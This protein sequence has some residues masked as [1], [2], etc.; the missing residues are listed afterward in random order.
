[1]KILHFSILLND[2]KSH[3]RHDYNISPGTRNNLKF[4]DRTVRERNELT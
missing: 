4:L 3:E 1:M 2:V